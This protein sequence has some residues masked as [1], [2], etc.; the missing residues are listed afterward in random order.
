[1]VKESI[2]VRAM[3]Q[4]LSIVKRPGLDRA[5]N[6]QNRGAPHSLNDRKRRKVVPT[7][8]PN[9]APQRDLT[10]FLCGDV[11]TGRGI[12]QILPH[13]SKPHPIESYVRSALR[14]VELAEAT[15]GPFPRAVPFDYVWGDAT[16]ELDRIRPDARIINLETAITTAEDAWAGKG[17]HYRMHPRNVECL[18]AARI[19]CCVLANNHVLDWGHRGLAETLRTLGQAGIRFAGAGRDESEAAA[20]CMILLPGA[21]RVLVFAF[22]MESAGVPREWAA[23]K[24]RA[25]ISLLRDLSPAS[26][27]AIV[28]RVEAVKRSGDIVI[29]SIHW[30]GNWGYAISRAERE[31]AHRLIDAGAIDLVHGHSSH[32][33]KAIEIHRDRPI[34]YGCGDF[35]NDYEGIGGH[36]PFR[37]DLK[38][39]VFPTIDAASGRL[40]R[41][42][43]TP[44]RVHRFR[45][46]RVEEPDARWPLARL[47]RDGEG[48]G[49]RL[50]LQSD[51]T[52]TAQW[53]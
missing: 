4:W 21:R 8:D 28:R 7:A 5:P 16:A 48:L 11:M 44:V 41:L 1:M 20:P 22:G 40:L 9:T 35:L 27:A 49:T 12:D 14:Y 33:P 53:G 51:G 45:V 46:N 19:D 31:F 13:P 6:E 42:D 23:G 50:E 38:L 37:P 32:H 25:G 18:S 3:G 43:L 17:I 10:L 30:G 36:A 34:L 29:A 39:M 26:A 24:D 2:A 52:F 47:N 15:G